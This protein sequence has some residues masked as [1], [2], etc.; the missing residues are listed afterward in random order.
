M[1]IAS[2]ITRTRRILV[3]DDDP[4]VLASL[5]LVLELEDY[6]V[7]PCTDG[8]AALECFH[9]HRGDL[10]LLDLNL[11]VKD[12]WSTLERIFAINPIVPIVLITARPNQFSRA[13]LARVD[14]IM[15]KPLDFKLLLETVAELLAQRIED[16]VARLEDTGPVTRLLN[17]AI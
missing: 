6:C 11:P 17:H 5:C 1:K 13:S 16:R 7:F 9:L 12:G 3:V 2:Q 15:E 8:R 14:A 4:A 10:V